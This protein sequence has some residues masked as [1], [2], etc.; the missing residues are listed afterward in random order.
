MAKSVYTQL[1][2]GNIHIVHGGQEF[3]VE[4]PSWLKLEAKH[5]ENNADLV[6]WLSEHDVLQ[7]VLHEG[8][9]Q[10]LISYRAKYRKTDKDGAQV[11]LTQE[12]IDEIELSI[13]KPSLITAPGTN[14][15]AGAKAKARAM[16]LQSLESANLPQEIIE[17]TMA[18]FDAK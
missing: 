1:T 13:F 12:E 18:E 8:L 17:K 9:R 16:L 11:R 2:D 6:D 14:T 4:L 3:N 15:Q 10:A 5:F 7:N